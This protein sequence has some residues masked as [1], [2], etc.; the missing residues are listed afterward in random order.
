MLRRGNR[1]MMGWWKNKK[2]VR[3]LVHLLLPLCVHWIA[4]EMTKSVLVDV[5]TSALC[6]GHSTCEEAIYLNGLQ[7]TVRPT[8]YICA[9]ARAYDHHLPTPALFLLICTSASVHVFIGI[10][11]GISLLLIVLKK[12]VN[13]IGWTLSLLGLW[14]EINRLVLLT[15]AYNS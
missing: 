15:V 2:E 1:K 5:T 13:I 14:F 12:M 11:S 3:L 4:E 10:W 8:T 6:P 7:Q 9:R